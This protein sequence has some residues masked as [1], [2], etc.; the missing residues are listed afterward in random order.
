M[1]EGCLLGEGPSGLWLKSG[2][3][4][5]GEGESRRRRSASRAH[6]L[7][8]KFSGQLYRVLVSVEI[9]VEFLG[10]RHSFAAHCALDPSARCRISAHGT[11][12]PP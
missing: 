12:L 4:R 6:A 8:N 2:H 3:M 10:V 7:P 5:K 11:L 1:G 9:Q